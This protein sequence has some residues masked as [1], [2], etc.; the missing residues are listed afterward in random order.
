MKLQHLFRTLV[1]LVMLV[2]AVAIALP[3]GA[4]EGT[5]VVVVRELTYW[6][7]TFSGQVDALRY[8]QWPFV[9]N[10]SRSFLVT[11]TPVAEGLTPLI[12]LLDGSGTEL[13]RGTGTLTSSQPAGNFSVQIQPAAGSG[14]Y[15]LTLRQVD[16]AQ[17]S[18]TTVV[19]PATAAVGETAA[20][21][22][23]LGAVPAEG[24]TSAEFTCTFDPARLE[25]SNIVATGLFGADA[26]TAVNGPQDG[27]FIVAIAG[28][29][30]NK[31]TADGGA[32][33]FNVKAL[34][35]GQ[36][37]IECRARVS[38]GDSLLTDLA[39]TPG[40]L[41]VTD[42]VVIAAQGTLTGEVLSG[43][44]ATISLYNADHTLV[45]SG[46]AAAGGTFSLA[47]A[48][49]TYTVI[50]TASGYLSAQ[51]SA[52][53]SAGGTTAKPSVSLIAGDIDGNSVIDQ[54]D[55]MTIGMSYNTAVPAAAD[56]NNDGIINVLDLE[57]LAANYRRS[58]AV[59][60]E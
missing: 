28:S 31:A 38:K 49:G 9:L 30:G 45:T 15:Y 3:V 41:T 1:L 34:Q 17:P 58:G 33:A 51:G 2:G 54:F 13:A 10:E 52:V 27:V 37:A 29:N 8:E 53:V 60:W 42:T 24:Y 59:A 16:L 35:P 50:A 26:A 20:V 7:A 5:V 39:S 23:D 36:A 43:K 40:S 14:L 25:A 47:A 18:V 44:P 21:T 32:L 4:Q 6:D 57:I 48:P 12:L 55:A 19:D 22:A 46:P 11:A 56:L